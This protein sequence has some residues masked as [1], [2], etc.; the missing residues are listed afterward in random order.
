METI[1]VGVD[2]D[3]IGVDGEGLARHGPTGVKPLQ[4]KPQ[5]LIAIRRDGELSPCNGAPL[6]CPIAGVNTA[7]AVAAVRRSKE[8]VLTLKDRPHHS[9]HP[10]T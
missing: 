10:V 1:F 7:N 4:H 8:L 3:L 2:I 6:P 9:S 5:M